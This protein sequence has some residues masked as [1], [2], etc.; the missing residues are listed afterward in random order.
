MAFKFEKL[1]VW[2]KA[3]EYTDLVYELSALFPREEEFNLKSQ[4]RRAATSIQLN[5]AEGSTGQTDDEQA[6]FLGLA[7]RSLYETVA[8][9]HQAIRRKFLVDTSLAQA[10]VLYQ[11]AETLAKMIQAMRGAIAPDKKWIRETQAEY[12]VE[13]REELNDAEWASSIVRR[14]SSNQGDQNAN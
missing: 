7:V 4:M 12:I 10:R 2:Q 5:I 3:M 14:P 1:E 11:Q 9:L 6:R 13:V 8:C